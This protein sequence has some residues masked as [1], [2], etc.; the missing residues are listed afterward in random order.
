[1]RT[2]IGKL[3]ALSAGILAL[4]LLP[5]AL[6]AQTTPGVS[7]SEMKFPIAGSPR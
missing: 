1:M 4:V 3:L 6:P 7:N 5:T 2:R